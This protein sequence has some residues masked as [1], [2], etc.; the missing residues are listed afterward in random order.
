MKKIV[1]LGLFVA[2]IVSCTQQEVKAPN[3][4]AWKVVSWENWAADTLNFKLPGTITGSEMKIV[5]KGNFLWVGRYKINDTTFYD[6]YGGGT[7][8]IDGNHVEETILYSVEK[9]M[10]GTTIRLLCELR[11]DTLIQTWPC[12]ENWVIDK[13]NYGIQKSVRAE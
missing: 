4:G 11:N 9:S 7:T 10:V 1:F 12:N 6:N 5:S 13:S 3:E 2:L 8:K